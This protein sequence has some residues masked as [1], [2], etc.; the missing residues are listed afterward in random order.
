MMDL[1]TLLDT[2]LKNNIKLSVDNENLKVN[3]AKGVLTPNITAALKANKK[4]LIEKLLGIKRQEKVPLPKTEIQQNAPLSYAQKRFWL[5]QSI[6][7]NSSAYHIPGSFGLSGQLS[8]SNFVS[9]LKAVVLRHNILRTVYSGDG[10]ELLQSVVNKS[11]MPI[12]VIDLSFQTNPG[13]LKE[14]IAAHKRQVFTEPFDLS[15]D[16]PFRIRIVTCSDCFSEVIL[17]VH[18]I[19]ADAWSIPIFLQELEQEYKRFMPV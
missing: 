7:P 5:L 16:W 17:C 12:E 13:I 8:I 19:A 10:N 9:A 1:D 3:A 18:H 11:Q 14:A 6:A 4:E 15:S 2:C